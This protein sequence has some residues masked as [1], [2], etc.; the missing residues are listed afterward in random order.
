M[1]EVWAARRVYTHCDGIVDDAYL[2]SVPHS[3]LRTGQRL[4][5]SEHY[6]RASIANAELLCRILHVGEGPTPP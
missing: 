3:T 4:R 5:V 2:A 1:R 6:S